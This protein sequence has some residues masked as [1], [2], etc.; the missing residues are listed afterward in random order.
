MN[1]HVWGVS[2][3]KYYLQTCSSTYFSVMRRNSIG[4]KKLLAGTDCRPAVQQPSEM[5]SH[6]KA[7]TES[8][9]LSSTGTSAGSELLL[10]LLKAV[11]FFLN[12]PEA[13]FLPPRGSPFA[14]RGTSTRLTAPVSRHGR[15][16]CGYVP[17]FRADLHQPTK[18]EDLAHSSL[19][20]RV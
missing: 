5:C 3:S 16:S 20:R 9:S 14:P 8:I 18:L 15:A 4:T 7:C 19:D 6:H 11:I 12:F 17:T 10:N 13:L 1:K 2:E